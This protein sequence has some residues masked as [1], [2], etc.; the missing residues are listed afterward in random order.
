MMTPNMLLESD[1]RYS[2]E[3]TENHG[4]ERKLSDKISRKRSWLSE[5]QNALM[6]YFAQSNLQMLVNGWSGN[7][8]ALALEYVCVEDVTYRGSTGK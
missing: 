6:R 4:F 2:N 3:T 1:I 7:G 5:W 8:T